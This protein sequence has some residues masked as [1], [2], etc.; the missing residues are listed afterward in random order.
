MVHMH[1]RGPDMR[2]QT[3]R[4]IYSI[5]AGV[6]FKS[7]LTKGCFPVPERTLDK[8][9]KV[10]LCHLN[11]P[12]QWMVPC[13]GRNTDSIGPA[14]PKSNLARLEHCAHWRLRAIFPQVPTDLLRRASLPKNLRVRTPNCL[15]DWDISFR[16]KSHEHSSLQVPHEFAIVFSNWIFLVL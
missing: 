15:S 5:A 13:D 14:D 6:G 1:I 3:I 12:D 2:I 10:P 11:R 7:L 9:S 8:W 16:V 4:S